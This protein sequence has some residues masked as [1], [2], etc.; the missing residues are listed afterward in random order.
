MEEK[1][2]PWDEVEPEGRV[3][4]GDDPGAKSP[5]VGQQVK[6]QRQRAKLGVINGGLSGKV[7]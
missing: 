5:Q 2:V 1:I 4:L 3:I 6:K 7:R